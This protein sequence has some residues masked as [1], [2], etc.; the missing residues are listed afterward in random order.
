MESVHLLLTMAAAKDWHV[1]HLDIKSMFLNG[2]LT[3]TVFI[4]QAPGFTVKGAEHM[5]LKLR[6][7]LY[8]LRQPLGRGTP[9]WTPPWVSLGSLAALYT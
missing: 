8:G 3:E 9:S 5:V 6:M 2:E 1:H 4:K 7:A